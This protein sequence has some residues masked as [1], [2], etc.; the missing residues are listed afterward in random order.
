[1]QLMMIEHEVHFESLL[2]D[3]VRHCCDDQLLLVKLLIRFHWLLTPLCH[4]PP[5]SLENTWD[6]LIRGDP[7]MMI[8]V[9]ISNLCPASQCARQTWQSCWMHCL[10]NLTN[11]LFEF[12]KKNY[13]HAGTVKRD[14]RVSH[15]LEHCDTAAEWCWIM[16][17][18][19]EKLYKETQ[20]K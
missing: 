10:P 4:G 6:T 2:S 7:G 16:I 18:F 8:R 17:V 13:K 5:E 9:L 19:Q 3:D 1:M 11:W 14:Q 12:Y 20:Y 15:Q